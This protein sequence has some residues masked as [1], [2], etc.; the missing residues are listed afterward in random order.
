MYRL[1]NAIEDWERSRKATVAILRRSAEELKS[2]Y[3]RNAN[4]ELECAQTSLIADFI[5]LGGVL[6]APFSGGLSLAA[7]GVSATLGIGSFIEKVN[8]NKK[9]ENKKQDVETKLRQ[10]ID[11]DEKAFEKVKLAEDKLIFFEEKL[12]EMKVDDVLLCIH[13]T[14]I[15]NLK[16]SVKDTRRDFQLQQMN[17]TGS[18]PSLEF[19][20]VANLNTALSGAEHVLQI[21]QTTAEVL[22]GR[23]TINQLLSTAE[24]VNKISQTTKSLATAKQAVV[25]SI[26][27]SQSVAKSTVTFTRVAKTADGMVKSAGVVSS[28][29]RAARVVKN[30]AQAGYAV[31]CARK[32]VEMTVKTVNNVR[33]ASNTVRSVTQLADNSGKII[34]TTRITTN[35]ARFSQTATT[36]ASVSKVGFAINVAVIPLDIYN[37]VVASDNLHRTH[38]DVRRIEDLAESLEGDMKK[39]M[40]ELKVR[41]EYMEK[42]HIQLRKIYLDHEKEVIYEYLQLVKRNME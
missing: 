21:T 2:S 11:E 33:Q 38:E 32:G 14:E 10:I 20:Q 16:V 23:R 24:S 25:T 7:V 12:Y 18:V 39:I 19:A 15:L 35:T 36:A 17:E 13:T 31:S 34:R 27:A 5:G 41:Y 28:A 26:Q 3:N 42:L 1:K 40:K 29:T 6:L 30:T 8:A 4:S 22:R 37:L 9:N